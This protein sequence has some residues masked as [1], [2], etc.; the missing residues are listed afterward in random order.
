MVKP[1]IIEG[2]ISTVT[3]S[4]TGERTIESHSSHLLQ[5][6]NCLMKNGHISAPDFNV[7]H[8]VKQLWKTKLFVA[9][10]L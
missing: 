1:W 2:D 10:T 8:A 3:K 5:H 6:K 9:V 7:G 4:G